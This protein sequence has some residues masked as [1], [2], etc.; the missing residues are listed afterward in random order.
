LTY[1]K[2]ENLSSWEDLMKKVSDELTDR[3]LDKA[4]LLKGII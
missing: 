1:S 2:K 4:K 3:G